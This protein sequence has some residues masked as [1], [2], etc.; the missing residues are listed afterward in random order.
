MAAFGFDH[1]NKSQTSTANH[2][3][4]RALSGPEELMLRFP[5]FD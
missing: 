4:E 3:R 1:V 5:G 2:R